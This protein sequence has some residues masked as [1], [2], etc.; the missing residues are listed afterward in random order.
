MSPLVRNK[1]TATAQ[2][3]PQVQWLQCDRR[4]LSPSYPRSQEEL[5]CALQTAQEPGWGALA[6]APRGFSL[7]F[8]GVWLQ[9]QCS[10]CTFQASGS[11]MSKRK[12][13]QLRSEAEVVAQT[14][15]LNARLDASPRTQGRCKRR[16]LGLLGL[17][18][19]PSLRRG[20]SQVGGRETGCAEGRF[21][22]LT[23]SPSSRF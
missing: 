23:P 10:G 16:H 22:N 13:Q 8:E 9:P 19:G 11:K 1:L 18:A 5:A 15:W 2:K 20:P 6:S 14:R 21:R 4:F 3:R 17:L 12:G 7:W